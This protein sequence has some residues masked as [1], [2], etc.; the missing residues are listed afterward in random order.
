MST[1]KYVI[2]LLFLITLSSSQIIFDFSNLNF[3]NSPI[4][5]ELK[6][7]IIETY[8]STVESFHYTPTF[9]TPYVQNEKT[10]TQIVSEAATNVSNPCTKPSKFVSFLNETVCLILKKIN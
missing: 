2:I 6:D 9:I 7:R 8:F 3:D 5:K 4:L 10:V 1:S